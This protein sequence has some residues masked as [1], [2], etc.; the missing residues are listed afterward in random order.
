MTTPISRWKTYC[1]GRAL[2][3]VARRTRKSGSS[4]NFSW[5]N[6][7]SRCCPISNQ[8]RIQGNFSTFYTWDISSLVNLFKFI[9]VM[10]LLSQTGSGALQFPLAKQII[11][12]APISAL[13]LLHDKWTLVPIIVSVVLRASP[14]RGVIFSQWTGWKRFLRI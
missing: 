10:H 14:L 12:P 8:L 2:E 6:G 5:Q 3:T 4:S 13:P 1:F 7:N 9:F 11:S